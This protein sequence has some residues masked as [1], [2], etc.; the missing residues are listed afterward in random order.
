MSVRTDQWHVTVP[1]KYLGEA[2]RTLREWAIAHAGTYQSQARKEIKAG[3]NSQWD[4]DGVC[5]VIRTLSNQLLPELQ[6]VRASIRTEGNGD[7]A[8][9]YVAHAVSWT[10]AMRPEEGHI[11]AVGSDLT[12]EDERPWGEGA[13]L[14][15]LTK[16]MRTIQEKGS[17]PTGGRTMTAHGRDALDEQNLGEAG[18]LVVLLP[19]N[20]EDE[21]CSLMSEVASEF[22]RH[23]N[24]VI[25][26]HGA[27]RAVGRSIENP[28][29][30]VK[31]NR[32]SFALFQRDIPGRPGRVTYM[33]DD[34]EEAKNTMRG[35]LA[36]RQHMEQ[37]SATQAMCSLT[38]LT[39]ALASNGMVR[40]PAGAAESNGTES[41]RVAVLEDQLEEARGEQ[42][43]LRE[44]LNRRDNELE[45]A[46]SALRGED[47]EPEE[48]EPRE[49]RRAVE[50]TLETGQRYPNLR[51][52]KTA[53]KPL[54]KHRQPNPTAEEIL[55]ALD[56]INRLAGAW[57]NTPNRQIGSWNRYFDNLTGW[58]YAVKESE[59]TIT[60]HGVERHF[61][62]EENDETLIIY[63]HL[64]YHAR[65]SSFQ[66]FFDLDEQHGQ[67]IVAYMGRHL[68]YATET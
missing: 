30:A 59:Q 38:E 64:T 45:A 40:I 61:R 54:G 29:E 34:P 48:E 10:A 63:R 17:R 47:D 13:G 50:S 12:S 39:A 9:T 35:A 65:N 7:G 1:K 57:R 67:W 43:R 19:W 8:T 14:D 5:I 21:P 11:I 44:M 22:S 4:R 23:Y 56:S 49:L 60:K 28:E 55:T 32:A 31:W 42:T 53:T 68:T 58:H 51:F 20:D 18:E 52:L 3:A 66:I 15:A 36:L 62:D 41:R 24:T 6:L 46:Y 33:T 37:M 27:A 16:A 2:G 26:D 25:L